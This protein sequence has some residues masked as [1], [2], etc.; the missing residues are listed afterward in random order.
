MNISIK[1]GNIIFN[2]PV[3]VASGTLVTASVSRGSRSM[4][5]L[6]SFTADGLRSLPGPGPRRQ[7]IS[8]PTG[9]W[10]LPGISG[11]IHARFSRGRKTAEMT[12]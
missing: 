9:Q 2:N 7:S 12:K 1:I 8:M 5:S 10:S 3:T 4:S 6:S 11:E